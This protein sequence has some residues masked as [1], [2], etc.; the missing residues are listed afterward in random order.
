MM[1]GVI[2]GTGLYDPD[3]IEN[4]EGIE[5]E[6]PFGQVAVLLGKIQG[7]KVCFIP[8]HGPLHRLPPHRVNYRG[9]ISAMKAAGVERVLSVNSV[10]SLDETI[11]PGSV[12]VPHDFI[13][14]TFRREQ[15]FFDDEVVHVDMT[16]PYCGEMRHTILKCAQKIWPHVREKGLYVC[17]E[18]PRFET[19]AEIKRLRMVGGDVVGM[20][21]CPEVVLAREKEMCYASICTVTNYGCGIS[22]T[23]LTVREVTAVVENNGVLMK[24]ALKQIVKSLPNERGC[25]CKDSLKEARL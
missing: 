11:Q 18:G 17:T 13:D 9:N 24:K 8:R 3:F 19:P 16:E 10:G 14:L 21:G 4:P 1:I 22:R 20:V 5:I 7:V 2:G 15:T 12:L 6:T 23:P 25:G